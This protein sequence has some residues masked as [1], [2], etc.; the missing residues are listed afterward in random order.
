MTL[1]V[2]H[3]KNCTTCKRALALLDKLK[4]D[5]EPI[6]IVTAPPTQKEL[7]GVLTRTGLPLKKLFNTSGQSYRAGNWGERLAEVSEGDALRALAADGKLIKRPV[8]LGEDFALVG[9]DEA[10]YRSRFGKTR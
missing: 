1:R 7:K 8:V 5:Y 4:V 6:D 9:F 2:F 10:A 3:Y